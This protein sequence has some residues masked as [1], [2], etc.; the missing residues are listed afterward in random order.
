MN[1]ELPLAEMTWGQLRAFTELG[2]DRLDEAE[3]TLVSDDDFRYIGLAIYGIA[4][5]LVQ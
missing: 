2:A 5:E 3:V 1:I 4:V